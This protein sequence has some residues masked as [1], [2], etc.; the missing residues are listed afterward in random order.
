MAC[1]LSNILNPVDRSPRSAK[2]TVSHSQSST[3]ESLVSS[4]ACS[5]PHKRRRSSLS[6]ETSN[7][8]G[9][10]VLDDSELTLPPQKGT[11]YNRRLNSSAN[12]VP[13]LPS[14]KRRR[15]ADIGHD[16]LLSVTIPIS[17]ANCK[18]FNIFQALLQN[19]ELL[20]EWS[21][22]LEIDDLVSLYAISKDFHYLA[23]KRFTALI[24]GQSVSKAPESSRTFIF[25]CYKDLCLRDPNR[26]QLRGLMGAIRVIPSFRWLRMVL[27]REKVVEDIVRSLYLE[28]HRMPV[29]V[30]LVIKKLWF[31]LD[32]S[33][34]LRRVALMHNEQFWTS[35]DLSIATLFFL[36]LDMRLT[37]PVTGTGSLGLRKMLL[38]QRSFSTLARV[39]QRKEMK[40]QLDMLRM[41]VRYNYNPP[42]RPRFDILGVKPHEV[43]RL[44]YEGWGHRKTRFIPI[45]ELVGREAL[46]R[47]LNMHHLFMDMM[48]YGYI[49]RETFEDF[50]DPPP[51]TFAG[52]EVASHEFQIADIDP[53]M[54]DMSGLDVTGDMD[55]SDMAGDSDE[56]DT[57]DDS[58]EEDLQDEEDS[59]ELGGNDSE[60][61]DEEASIG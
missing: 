44:Q 11:D 10:N 41:K 34:N 6:T 5:S 46:K 9:T 57:D 3:Q 54:P 49:N 16:A 37:D 39:L 2:S 55:D 43:G 42:F 58:E 28:G 19:A 31:T 24:L 30:T 21:K 27:F 14:P 13:L 20:F 1:P 53:Q 12:R 51:N 35:K 7:V 59:E 8:D 38:N 47:K 29:R 40:R 23:N 15:I 48:I 26:T 52:Q 22:Q 56:D 4:V 61:V 25:C 50:K 17:E 45:D 33:D 36:K 18:P 60:V 32:L